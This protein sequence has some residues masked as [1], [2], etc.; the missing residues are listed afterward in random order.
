VAELSLDDDQRH[1]FARHLNGVGVPEL[2][3]REPSTHTCCG[4]GPAQVR[5]GGG[6]RPRSPARGT[7]DNAEER[8]NGELHSQLERLVTEIGTLLA[9]EH[10]VMLPAMLV[11][12]LLRRDEYSGHMHHHAPAEQ[13]LAA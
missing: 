9:I 4:G 6:A 8:P 13:Q 3:W 11:A 1:P 2:M 12:M 10:A 5:P 7:V